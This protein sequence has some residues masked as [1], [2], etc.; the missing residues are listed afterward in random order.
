M[1]PRRHNLRPAVVALLRRMRLELMRARL[2]HEVAP[3]QLLG[4]Q[5]RANYAV[6][7]A[8]LGSSVDTAQSLGWLEHTPATWGCLGL[9]D[10]QPAS[11][12]CDADDHGCIS[13]RCHSSRR[14][15]AA[16]CVPPL[17]RRLGRL[18]ASTQQ[19]SEIC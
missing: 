15:R 5:V 18:P 16:H 14:A 13:A 2:A 10:E 1:P 9:W 19:R 7:M 11:W 12:P 17:S 3:K 6:S 4:D 8:L